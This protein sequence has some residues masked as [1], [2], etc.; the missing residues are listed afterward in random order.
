M[1]S[2]L[3][4][5]APPL[6]RRVLY[7]F[8]GLLYWSG[9]GHAWLRAHGGAGAII[10]NYHSVADADAASWID[11]RNR[12][13]PQDFARQME[14][15]ARHRHVIA[16]DALLDALEG[17]RPLRAGSVVLTFDDGYRDNL[18]VVAPM[19]ERLGLPAVVYV[20]TGVIT[21]GEPQW[22]DR[23][24]SAFRTRRRHRFRS[25]SAPELDLDLGTAAGCAAAYRALSDRLLASGAAERGRLLDELD[26]QL[27]SDAGMPGL[28][29]SW[30]ELRR[31]RDRHR[32]IAI[33]LHTADHVDLT[34]LGS[35]AV[36]D[37]LAR[38]LAE[39]ERELGS[40]PAHF[41]YPYNRASAATRRI[42]AEFGFRSAVCSGRDC[43]IGPGSDPLALARRDV[44]RSM[45]LLRFW[46]SGAYPQLPLRIAGRA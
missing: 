4:D 12:M 14:F 5:D 23:L 19:L 35:T 33:G 36:K 8:E 26:E 27:E 37:E 32:G 40:R 29:L 31:L 6:R 7:A 13:S 28:T 3:P 44:P 42:V 38:S 20:P 39:A 2:F 17:D 43:L 11:P 46:T 30:E 1:D 9:A 18:E 25:A 15:L 45:T 34:A 21:R 16:M 41:A 22:A 10:L 24:Y